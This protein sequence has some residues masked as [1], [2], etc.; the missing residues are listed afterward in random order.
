METIIIA[1]IIVNFYIAYCLF[2]K[3]HNQK[4]DFKKEQESK[5]YFNNSIIT[6]EITTYKAGCYTKGLTVKKT[7]NKVEFFQQAK[8]CDTGLLY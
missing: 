4:K 6:D 2:K 5:K 1:A 7:G 8:V 3:A